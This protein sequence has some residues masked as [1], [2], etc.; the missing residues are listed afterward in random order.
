LGVIMS[1]AEI[2]RNYLD[3][4]KPEQRI[5]HLQDIMHSTRQM[6][7]LMEEILFLGRVESGRMEARLSPVVLGTLCRQ[8]VDQQTAATSGKCPI[9]LSAAEID[10]PAHCD[11]V[12]VRHI[13][14]NL[15]ENAVKYSAPGSPVHLSAAREGSDAVFTVSDRGIGIPEPD[16]KHLFEAFHRGKNASDIP[17]T[18]LGLTMARHAIRNLGGD[19]EMLPRPEGGTI[20]RMYHPLS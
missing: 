6:A 12:L 20:A 13:L 10:A 9:R 11:E 2:L 3:R 18:G 8:L 17:G 14:G 16:L 5:G 1:S 15:V 4:I 7:A 19:L